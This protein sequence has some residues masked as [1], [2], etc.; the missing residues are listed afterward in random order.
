MEGRLYPR[1]ECHFYY[2]QETSTSRRHFYYFSVSDELLLLPG[3]GDGE[4]RVG[5]EISFCRVAS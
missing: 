3:D 2:F 5:L 1:I 4:E